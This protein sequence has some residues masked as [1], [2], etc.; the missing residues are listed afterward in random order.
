MVNH[1][2]FK[3]RKPL[4]IYN[5]AMVALSGYLFYE[6]NHLKKQEIP[7]IENSPLVSCRWLVKWLFI[8][9]STCRLFSLT[10]CYES[11]DKILSSI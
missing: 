4:I 10:D 7:L 1:L 2:A 5:F 11:N 9:L 6:V 8:R 3:I